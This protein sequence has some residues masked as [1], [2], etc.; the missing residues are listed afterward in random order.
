MTQKAKLETLQDYDITV[1]G[2]HMAVTDA[3]KKYAIDKISK[4]DRFHTRIAEVSVTMDIQRE[5][6]IVDIGLKVNNFRVKSHASANEMYVSI[7]RAVDKIQAQLRRYKTRLAE[8]S[9]KHLAE[10]EMTVNVIKPAAEEIA[11]V[12][13]EIEEETLR[14][15]EEVYKPHQIVRRESR[16]LKTLNPAEAM[17]KME[18]SGDFFLVFRNEQDMKIKV[19]Y[20]RSDGNYGVIEPE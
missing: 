11:A 1:T 12:N 10:V 16:S 8:H 20:R 7:D 5:M 18:L 9:A 6:N 14:R 13:D 3:M 19:I 2:R 17:M 15:M 4:I